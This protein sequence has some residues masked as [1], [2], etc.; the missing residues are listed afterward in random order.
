MNEIWNILREFESKD[1][2]YRYYKNKFDYEL[3]S[4]K[5]L[6]INSTFIQWREY[7]TSAATSNIAVKPLLQYYW[8]VALSRGLILILNSSSRE[9]NI[10]P[11]HWLSIKNFNE[12]NSSWLIEDIILKA[13]DW[14]FGELIK[15]TQNRSYFRAWSS[16]INWK[17]DYELPPSKDFEFSFKELMFSFPDLSKSISAW[18]WIDP[19]IRT[20]ETLKVVDSKYEIEINGKYNKDHFDLIFPIDYFTDLEFI[21]IGGKCLVKFSSNKLPNFAQKWSSAF[22]VIWDACVI[23]PFKNKIFLN[24][25]SSMYATSFILGDISRYHPSLWNNINKSI[26]RDAI[27]PFAISYM[28]FIE[29]RF[30]QIILD[31]LNA[32]YQL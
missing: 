27:L 14:T 26:N 29:K 3:K 12:I 19:P 10:K 21:E 16:W 18:I 24:T 17:I 9:N 11:S 1:I 7:F 32:P 28:D 15:V 13:W 22:Q 4:E 6:E 31:F 5:L 23:P 25:I 20:F 8:I 2:V 30:P